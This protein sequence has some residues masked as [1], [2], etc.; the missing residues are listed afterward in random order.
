[1]HKKRKQRVIFIVVLLLGFSC[2]TALVLYAMKQ[3]I[4]LFHTPSEIVLG[5]VPVEKLF[6]VGGLVVK[7]SVVKGNDGLTTEFNL[8]DATE[9]VT[10]RYIGLL[11]DLFR[12]GQGIVAQGKLNKEGIFVAQEVL[13]KHDENY[14]PPDV[15]SALRESGSSHPE[16]IPKGSY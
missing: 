12:E 2:A 7:G 9:I 1:V 6:R 4:M 16:N 11:P 15:A 5:K 13:A 8:T 10:I 14:M 3:N